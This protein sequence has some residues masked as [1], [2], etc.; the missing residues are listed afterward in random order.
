MNIGIPWLAFALSTGILSTL[1]QGI[2]AEPPGPEAPVIT[3]KGTIGIDL[4]ETTPL[5][6][7]NKLYRMEWFRD[8]SIRRIMD[9]DSGAETKKARHI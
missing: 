9:H 4:V 8:G 7:Q 6:F 5:V 1:S 2:A 3:K